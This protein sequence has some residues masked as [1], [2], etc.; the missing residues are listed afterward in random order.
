MVAG[1]ECY[2]CYLRS[3]FA[4]ADSGGFEKP[5]LRK[6]KRWRQHPA[7]DSTTKNM[8]IIFTIL[9]ILTFN[10]AYGFNRLDTIANWQI[11]YGDKLVV[12]GHEPNA[13]NPEIGIITVKGQIEKL[14]IFYRYDAVKPERRTIKITSGTETLYNQPQELKDNHPTLL[15]LK[16]IIKNKKGTFE[17]QIY[18]TD[19]I[20]TEKNRLIGKIR[21]EN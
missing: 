10:T 20:T 18:Y 4:H 15:D 12:S 3:T 8:R 11:Y 19:D 5:P 13:R 17:I 7:T 9:T 6:H 21:I 16:E 14:K 1:R 2:K